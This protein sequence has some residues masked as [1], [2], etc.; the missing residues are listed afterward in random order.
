MQVHLV[1]YV[2]WVVA[3]VCQF[4]EK[5]SKLCLLLLECFLAKQNSN[6]NLHNIFQVHSTVTKEEKIKN[7]KK[8]RESN[9]DEDGFDEDDACS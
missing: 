1:I 9:R 3:G 4:L 2:L 5:Q 6:N 8:N 7:S